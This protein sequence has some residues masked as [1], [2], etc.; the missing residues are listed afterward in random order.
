M[1]RSRAFFI[2]TWGC[3]MNVLDGQ[4]MAG[5][6]EA[7]G[8]RK[9]DG[10]EKADLILLNTCNVREKAETKV[11][12]EL[13]RLRNWKRERTG[14]LLG[15]TGCVAQQSST[16]ILEDLPFVDFV[17][18][19]GSVER[20]PEAIDAAAAGERAEIVDLP[21][22]SPVY[23]FETIS[24]EP[25]SQAYVTIIEGCDQFC[26]F[27]VVPFTRGRERSRRASEIESEVRGLT[28]RGYSEITLLGQT[29]NAYACPDTGSGLAGLL[30]RLAPIPGLRR[31]RFLT[32]HPSFLGD[33]LIDAI[34]RNRNVSRY[35]HLPAQSGSDRVLSRMK[36][37]YDSTRYREI[38]RRVREKVPDIAL[39]SDFIVGFPGETDEDF[40][41]TLE[42]VEEVRFASVFAFLYSRR[43][44]TA[45]AR[46][47]A[48]TEVAPE[49][50]RERLE[51][52]LEIQRKIQKEINRG[53]EGTTF[54]IRVEGESRQ[55]RTLMGRTSC[56]RIVHFPRPKDPEAAPRPGAFVEVRISRGLEHS[57]LGNV[58]AAET[59]TP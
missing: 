34:A 8:Y 59:V 45:A 2:E 30:D 54:S 39:S 51:R 10:P 4:R 50:A 17:I 25:G 24:R 33:D 41:A 13:G 49:C 47:G 37:R 18:G 44:G 6:L 23:Q 3:Q 56:N 36:R 1:T 53:L 58:V 11:Y 38:V 7:R 28:D 43:S 52:L 27:C 9:V 46:W 21:T 57:L 22:D 55:G 14:R 40:R 35:L 12:S 42:L 15:V 20:L 32:S 26:T 29:V 5:L 31:L 48:E 19:T 16:G